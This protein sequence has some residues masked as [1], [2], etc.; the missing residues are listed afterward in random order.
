MLPS[1]YQMHL[2]S[3]LDDVQLMTLEILVD[4]LQKERRVTV[5]RLAM[6]FPQPILFHSR[7]RHVQRFLDI[8]SL[9]PQT[10]WFPIL[11]DWLAQTFASSQR[12]SIVIDR[13]QWDTYNILMVSL[14]YG[15]RAIPLHWTLLDKRGQ[16]SL[17]EQQFVLRPVFHLLQ[18]YEIVVL[19]DREFHS[20]ALADW[21]VDQDVSFVLRLPKS[22]TVQLTPDSDFER[23]D[24]LPLSP[25]MAV[26]EVH[27]QVTQQKGFGTF[28]LALRWK[29]P[30]RTAQANEVW[31]LLTDLE[32]LDDALSTYTQRFA[33]E[34]LFRDLK[35][36][37]YNLEDCRADPHRVFTLILLMCV[38]SQLRHP[39]HGNF[40]TLTSFFQQPI[41]RN[42]GRSN[43]SLTEHSGD[44]KQI[45]DKRFRMKTQ[46]GV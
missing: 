26:H 46:K 21:L 18:A 7:R 42:F 28:N 38:F 27:V 24:S 11:T 43:V 12:L 16:S 33:T 30:S 45:S 8:P 29:R 44:S 17:G 14:V 25:G 13:T 3:H 39:I 2:Q 22:T 10:V 4:L 6:L 31:Y 23:L 20:V 35:S 32:S 36:G 5:E 37:G 41:L 9:N 40:G 1:S 19:G 34:P 15:K